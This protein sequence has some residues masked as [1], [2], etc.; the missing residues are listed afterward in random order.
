MDKYLIEDLNSIWLKPIERVYIAPEEEKDVN[1]ISEML[2][3]EFK[4]NI[5][6][7]IYKIMYNEYTKR[8]H[9]NLYKK[10]LIKRQIIKN[11][12][13]NFMNITINMAKE[14]LDTIKKQIL[15]QELVEIL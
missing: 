10:L 2:I 9:A 12:S 8:P 7:V 13:E 15:E 14:K 1:Y 6:N 3:S 5:D 11:V 4:S